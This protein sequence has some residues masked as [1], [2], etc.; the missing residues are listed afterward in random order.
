[1]EPEYQVKGSSIQ[2]KFA[3]VAERFGPEAE[4]RLRE[5][6]LDHDHYPILDALWYPFDFY[7][8]VNQAIVRDFFAGDLTRLREVGQF[9][10]EKA[11]TETYRA[12][13]QSGDFVG[14]LTNVSRLHKQFYSVGE[15]RVSVGEDGRYC[16]IELRGKP[17]YPEAD[18][19]VAEGFYVGAAKL[20]GLNDVASRFRVDENG[21]TFEMKWGGAG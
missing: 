6:F 16:R 7:L 4:S 10:A 1:M 17:Y 21:A 2:S 3:F 5:Q 14:F 20:M 13:I 18:L 19:Y 15:Q 11:L 9:S 12:Y 8:A